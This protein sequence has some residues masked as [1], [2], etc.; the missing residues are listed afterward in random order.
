M[1]AAKNYDMQVKLLTIGNS[2]EPGMATGWEPHARAFTAA[3]VSAAQ[4]TQDTFSPTFITT[5]G[6]DFKIKIVKCV[7]TFRTA[8]SP[9]THGSGPLRA[10]PARYHAHHDITRDLHFTCT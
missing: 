3:L 4:Y 6:I 2:G 1:A 9:H 7:P 8:V 10:V 5:I